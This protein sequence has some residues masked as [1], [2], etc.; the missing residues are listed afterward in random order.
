MTVNKIKR[1]K[2][3]FIAAPSK[4]CV[5]T[6]FLMMTIQVYGEFGPL[7]THKNP[8]ILHAHYLNILIHRIYREKGCNIR[9]EDLI[10]EN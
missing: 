4:S 7:W 10:N 3:T 2:K 5:H 6:L 1:Q 8:T 9:T